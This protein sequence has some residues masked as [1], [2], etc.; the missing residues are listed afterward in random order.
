MTLLEIGN[1]TIKLA[2]PTGTSFAI[3]RFDPAG[4]HALVRRCAGLSGPIVCAPVGSS[5]VGDPLGRLRDAGI[6]IRVIE[7]RE[8]AD[9]VGNSYDTPDTLGLD[10][11]FNVMGLEGDGV[12]ISC[13][14]AITIDAIAGGK[15]LWGAILPGFRTAAEGLHLRIPALPVAELDSMT[16]MPARST[17]SSVA[18][19][20]LLGTMHAVR[21][22]VG[23]LAL[24][25]LGGDAQRILITGGD[26]ATLQRLWPPGS[27]PEIDEALLF[28]GMLRLVRNW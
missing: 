27:L 21:G 20:V 18:N 6:D 9:V 28:R 13:G 16:M 11:I 24:R 10:R 17:I 26:A 5:P 3:E 1:S 15:P 22:I 7:R 23:E 2:F 8:L 25:A 4:I 12:V 14:T 19:G